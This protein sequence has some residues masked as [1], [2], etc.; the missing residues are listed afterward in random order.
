MNT[1]LS[2]TGLSK[3]YGKIQALKNVSLEI[4]KGSVFGILGPNGSGKTTLM[5]IVLDIL[6]ADTGN[7]SWFEQPN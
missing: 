5:S 4:P 6:R 7:Y 3:S 2:I 1:I